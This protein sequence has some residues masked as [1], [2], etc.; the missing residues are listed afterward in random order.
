MSVPT[1][2]ATS[3]INP[4]QDGQTWAFSNVAKNLAF[5]CVL[6]Y[7]LSRGPLSAR[8]IRM[9]WNSFLDQNKNATV[10]GWLSLFLGV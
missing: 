7:P 10:A 2:L 9:D 8:L 4:F 5:V 3:T 6:K 1:V